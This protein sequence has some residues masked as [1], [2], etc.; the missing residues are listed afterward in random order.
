MC[1]PTKSLI[2]AFSLLF[3]F[4]LFCHADSARFYRILKLYSDP[5]IAPPTV[6]CFYRTYDSKTTDSVPSEQGMLQENDETK[7]FKRTATHDLGQRAF[8]SRVTPANNAR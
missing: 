2:A 3:L 7:V 6:S 4:A 1:E 5:T 8:G